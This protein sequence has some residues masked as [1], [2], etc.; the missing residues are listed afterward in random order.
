MT[1]RPLWG[2]HLA[3]TCQP[4]R[5][6]YTEFE[7]PV[8]NRTKKIGRCPQKNLKGVTCPWP[9]HLWSMFYHQLASSRNLPVC[10]L[11]FTNPSTLIT[12]SLCLSAPHYTTRTGS[13]VIICF[14]ERQL[15]FTFTIYCRPSVCRLSVTFVHPTQ[16][17]EIFGN[18]STPFGTLA[19]RWYPRRIYRDRPRGTPPSGLLNARGVVKYSDFVL[20]EC[21]IS[22]TMQD[23]R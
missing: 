10:L 19:I 15:T 2:Y 7:V 18:V 5:P 1:I 4:S 16:P 12:D 17:V 13:P 9:P 11:S 23:R 6:A 22:G 14:S 21:Y 3:C 8:F 20:I